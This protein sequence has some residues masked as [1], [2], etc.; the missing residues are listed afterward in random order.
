MLL[1]YEFHTVLKYKMVT[2]ISFISL[3][4]RSK[5]MFAQANIGHFNM[6]K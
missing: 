6:D 5:N 2:R 1:D 3:T 4:T